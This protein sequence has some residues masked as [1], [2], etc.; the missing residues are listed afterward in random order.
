MFTPEALDAL[1][2]GDVEW[3]RRNVRARYRTRVLDYAIHVSSR[4]GRSALT[5]PPRITIGTIHSVKGGEADVVY[6]F[7]DLSP[8]GI[9]QYRRP[10]GRASIIRTFFVGMTR[11]RSEL[12]L[13]G[14]SSKRCP[15]TWF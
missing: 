9:E 10:E 15:I 8:A 14:A 7:P 3:F 5:D 2:R 12:V 6:L 11:A 13:C 1:A 4:F